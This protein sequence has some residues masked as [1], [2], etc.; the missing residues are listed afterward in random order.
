MQKSKNGVKKSYIICQC[1]G[2]AISISI[3]TEMT[4]ISA[5]L[6]SNEQFPIESQGIL[7]VIIQ[8][9]SVMGGALW[10]GKSMEYNKMISC[11]I[12]AAAYCFIMVGMA[13]LFLD[14]IS[15][16]FYTGLIACAAGWILGAL[17][18]TIHK[19]AQKRI[20]KRRRAR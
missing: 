19:P 13:M 8:L 1:I 14:G 2:I 9:L 3:T 5:L 7:A 11:G 18:S 12:L 4:L 15:N 16:R 20:Y 17:L 6:I 10:V